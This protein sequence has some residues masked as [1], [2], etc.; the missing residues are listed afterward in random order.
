MG[1]KLLLLIAGQKKDFIFSDEYL[2]SKWIRMYLITSEA[3]K[4]YLD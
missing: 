3:E 2:Q 1:I 4:K